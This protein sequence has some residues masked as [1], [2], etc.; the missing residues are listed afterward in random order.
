VFGDLL[1]AHQTHHECG[2]YPVVIEVVAAQV[3]NRCNH[4]DLH[5]GDPGDVGGDGH[6]KRGQAADVGHETLCGGKAHMVIDDRGDRFISRA[7]VPL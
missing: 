4:A 6:R 5:G 2:A 7:G 1:A 3:R